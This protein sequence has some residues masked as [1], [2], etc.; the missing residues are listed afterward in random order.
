MVLAGFSEV[1]GASKRG[2]LQHLTPWRVSQH[3]LA[4]QADALRSANESLSH[5][6]CALLK[7]PLACWDLGCLSL[8]ASPLKPFLRSLQP[9]GSCGYEL[10]WFSKPDVLGT[11]L[12]SAGLKRWGVHAGY[13]LFVPQGEAPDL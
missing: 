7:W 9:S 13:K 11:R 10:H 4:P 8:H 6:A 5:V 12:S 1:D 3:A 2:A